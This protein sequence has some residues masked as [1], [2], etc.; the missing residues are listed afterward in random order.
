MMTL[1]LIILLV[2]G[3]FVTNFSYSQKRVFIS[4]NQSD[5]L[6]GRI[7]NEVQV[8]SKE[9]INSCDILLRSDEAIVIKKECSQYLIKPKKDSGIITIHCL[10]NERKIDSFFYVVNSIPEPTITVYPKKNYHTGRVNYFIDSVNAVVLLN[11]NRILSA[12]IN[13]FDLIIAKKG[14]AIKKMHCIGNQLSAEQKVELKEILPKLAKGDTIV[15]ENILLTFEDF[16][17]HVKKYV[18]KIN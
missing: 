5:F 9:G 3:L 4:E 15:L 8:Y 10:L 16:T 1:R 6:F 7:Y 14:K 18:I 13:G 2:T 12:N 11:G 17:K